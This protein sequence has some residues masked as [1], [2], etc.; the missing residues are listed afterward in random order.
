MLPLRMVQGLTAIALAVATVTWSGAA[1]ADAGARTAARRGPA[2]SHK[3]IVPPNNP[4]KNL[5]P[6]PAFY[7]SAHCMGGGDGSKCNSIVLRAVTHAREVL[8][9]FGGMSFSLAAYERLTPDEQL[10]VTANLER[11]NRG[12]PAAVVL[13]RSLDKVAQDGANADTD[14]PLNEVS[15]PLPGGGNWVSLGGNWAGG[16][17]NPLGADYV[18]MYD[19]GPGWGHRDNILG[20]FAT[21][22]SCGGARHELAMG[23]GH[24]TKGEAYGDS[25]TELFAGVCGPT[26]TDVVLTWAK[27]KKLLD[28]TG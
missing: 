24:V 18:W 12:L 27:A 20:T 10:F 21:A 19:D 6:D 7:D 9:K 4:A 17:D 1:T 8:E 11:A 16:W 14:P 25:E 22:S 26:P 5:T 3:G 13:S 28:I 23:A 2:V 15:N